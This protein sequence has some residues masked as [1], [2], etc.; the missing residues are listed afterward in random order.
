[1][2]DRTGD[3][4]RRIEFS[5]CSEGGARYQAASGF[6][7]VRGSSVPS[8]HRPR[9]GLRP[10]LRPKRT[11]SGRWNDDLG[12]RWNPD[13]APA[14][15]PVGKPNSAGKG[16]ER[17]EHDEAEGADEMAEDGTERM[18]EEIAGGDKAHRP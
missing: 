16:D 1:M 8:R 12:P 9:R 17:A 2:V 13:L 10:S 15:Q 3:L 7:V 6:T 14:L 4:P 11:S 18:A 5:P